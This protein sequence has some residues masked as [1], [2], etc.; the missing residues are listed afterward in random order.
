MKKR[1]IYFLILTA[2]I[3]LA[4]GA[5]TATADVE[6]NETNFPDD[7][8]R[9]YVSETFDTD[10]D[11]ILS[12]AER[13]VPTVIDCLGKQIQSLKGVEFFPSLKELV[14]C[15]NQLTELDVSDNPKLTYLNCY[16]NQLTDLDISMLTELEDLRC[17]Y[18]D[19]TALNT[20]SNR[21]LKILRCYHTKI[22]SLKLQNNTLLENLEI[23]GNPNL[24]SVNI[25]AC[26]ILCELAKEEPR[27]Y[28]DNVYIYGDESTGKC[29][30]ADQ[31]LILITE[32]GCGE[33]TPKPT[34]APEER[35]AALLDI[36]SPVAGS[37]QEA[38][39]VE[40][41]VNYH[42]T[43]CVF[44]PVGGVSDTSKFLSY[45]TPTTLSVW[46]NDEDEL[47]ASETIYPE[48]LTT[49][50]SSSQTHVADLNLTRPGSYTIIA[51]V[52]GH[53]LI[54]L[55][56]R[57]STV[58]FTVN[59]PPATPTPEPTEEPTP[60]PTEEPTPEPTEEPTPKPTEEPTPEPTEE[61]T[62]EP[63][64]EPTPKP[65][66]TP[67]PEDPT[68]A[69][70]KGLKY[71]LN[72]K[73]KTAVFTQPKN[74]KI[75][76]ITVP[77]TITVKNKTYKVTE[78]GANACKGMSKLA[79]VSIGKNVTKIGKNAFIA[80]KVLKTVTGGAGVTSIGD[81][82]FASCV[83]LTSVPA[84]PKLTTIG[85][86][87]CK[88]CKLL[89]KITLSAKVKTI[90]KNAFNGCAKL[91]T[92]TIKTKLLK[93]KTVGANAFKGIYSKPTVTCPKGMAKTYKK[94]L[95]KKGMPKKAVFK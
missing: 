51:T 28:E 69:T 34:E 8:F 22:S 19:L 55:A 72:S 33:P 11:G 60:E 45:C 29:I 87:A 64:E 81:S 43:N 13:T 7:N 50:T 4:L 67:E 2:V 85:A 63:T 75:T 20:S 84:F 89:P 82:A 78:I 47:I 86:N 59:A 52:P 32:S 10:G 49:F 15:L 46:Y 30:F 70:V 23:D 80:C 93:D 54:P 1:W 18:N 56:S 71:S 79:K 42:V 92:I 65:T 5:G 38:G 61:P 57:S 83:K 91:K 74:R 40:V 17:S 48:G 26:P 53:S 35:R 41:V 62:P 12:L 44:W 73:K 3:I 6:I 14:C 36:L 24:H 66:A 88:G 27:E 31:S 95:M 39:T 16:S 68:T 58:T 21:K 25:S 77:D 94:L 76:S 9:N 37:E 90:G